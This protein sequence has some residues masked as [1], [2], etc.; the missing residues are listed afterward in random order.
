MPLLK[1]G[2][3]TSSIFPSQ[4]HQFLTESGT[5]IPQKCQTAN[6]MEQREAR[7]LSLHN[8]DFIL[9]HFLFQACKICTNI[10]RLYLFSTSATGRR[11][12]LKNVFRKGLDQLLVN[13][14]TKNGSLDRISGLFSS[15]AAGSWKDKAGKGSFCSCPCF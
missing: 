5:K 11:G 1:S 13:K 8:Q 4:C 9:W 15:W 10:Q 14:F 7:G 2:T 6:G 3:E 12:G